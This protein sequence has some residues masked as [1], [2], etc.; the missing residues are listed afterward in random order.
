MG[1]AMKI[2]KKL[3]VFI[4]LQISLMFITGELYA[5]KEKRNEIIDMM[6][7]IEEAISAVAD[8]VGSAV[9]SVSTEKT[10]LVSSYYRSFGDDIFDQFLQDFFY[11]D[12]PQRAYKQVGL[13]SGVII[14]QQG[15]ILTNEHVIGGAEKITVTLADG[16]QF[17]AKL[18]GADF[19]SDLAIIKIEADDLPFAPLGDSDEL[20]TG[21]WAIAIGNPFGFAVQSPKPTVTFGVISALHRAL[22]RTS[23][24][25]RA[26]LDLIQTDAAINPG[27][28]GGP[29]VNIRG[30]IIG[31]NVAIFSTSGGSEGIGFAIPINE[32]KLILDKLVK[33]EKVLYGWLGIGVQDLNHALAEYFDLKKPEGVLILQVVKGSPAEFAGL[34]PEDIIIK[35][36]DKKVKNTLE[37]LKL[38]G[39][40]KAAEKVK[41]KIIRNSLPRTLKVTLGGKSTE[42]NIL[43]AEN[44]IT[45]K[46][47]SH[48]HSDKRAVKMPPKQWRGLKVAQLSEEFARNFGLDNTKGVIVTDVITDSPAHKAGIKVKD[49]ISRINTTEINTIEDYFIAIASVTGNAL[50]KTTRGYFMLSE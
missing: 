36:N 34:Q 26:Y 8:N 18:K 49:I 11:G 32:A 19:R 38:I 2:R 16:R 46:Q 42:N 24:R 41:L 31:I 12:I 47:A 30:E 35:Y 9:V 44:I 25:G 4:G 39:H 23:S 43:V 48:P 6:T 21:Q 29:L 22:P 3:I 50:I 14:D 7:Q 20:K 5:A 45:K 28:S 10:T 33:G 27:N 37:F 13:G 40:S 17:L 1:L 15:H